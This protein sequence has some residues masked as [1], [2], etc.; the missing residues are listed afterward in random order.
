MLGPDEFVVVVVCMCG[1]RLKSC[2]WEKKGVKS[3]N[4]VVGS[5]LT[6]IDT[7]QGQVEFACICIHNQLRGNEVTCCV[8][9]LEV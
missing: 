4:Y 1:W 3:V 2:N 8:S 6:A 9:V 7:N 5:V